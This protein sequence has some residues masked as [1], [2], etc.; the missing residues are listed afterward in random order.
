MTAW[1]GIIGTLLGALLG[2]SFLECQ[3][4]QAKT[5]AV[6]RK[7]ISDAAADQILK[8]GIT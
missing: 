6:A 8:A 3:R 7:Y 4:M 1:I 2:G 5:M